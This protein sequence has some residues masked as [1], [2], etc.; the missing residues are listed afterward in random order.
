MSHNQNQGNFTK[1]RAHRDVRE[2][3]DVIWGASISALIGALLPA[4]C[5]DWLSDVTGCRLTEQLQQNSRQF[6][7]A[8]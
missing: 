7:N 6:S 5:S 1:G 8:K 2:H 3:Y 4:L